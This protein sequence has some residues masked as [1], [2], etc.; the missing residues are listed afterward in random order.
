M[1]FIE[2]IGFIIAML[3]FFVI[4]TK[5][6]REERRRRQQA[7]EYEGE[8]ERQDEDLRE[9]LESL[10]IHPGKEPPKQ[11]PPPP[12]LPERAGSPEVKVSPEKP[13]YEG[14]EE[15]KHLIEAGL[16]SEWKKS[17]I[18]PIKYEIEA[19]KEEAFRDYYAKEAPKRGRPVPHHEDAYM[20]R[21]KQQ[22][23]V[24][25]A[26]KNVDSLKQAVI[27]REILGPPKGM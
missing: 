9:L 10:D 11:V 8:S 13:A 1:T 5:Q 24:Q 12:P 16:R 14:I 17:K 18:G 4:I 20:I 27:L 26:L 6:A 7:E 15:D 2:F 25:K 3:A 23:R 22:T 19:E 21:R